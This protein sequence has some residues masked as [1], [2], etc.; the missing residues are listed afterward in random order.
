MSA[1]GRLAL[2]GALGALYGACAMSLV[3]L[4]LRRARLIDKM[5]PQ[6][7][8]EWAAR[9]MNMEPPGVP[10]GH[11]A[12]DQALH[13]I[14]SVGWGALAAPVLF[15]SG[16]RRSLGVGGLFGLGLW[17]LGPMLVFPMLKIARP[18]WRSSAVENLTN[19][20][21]HLVYGLGVQLVTEEMARQR[22]RGPS[23]DLTRHLTRVG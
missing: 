16:R 3:R 4:G 17:A 18:P 19:I 10:A 5:V 8:T 7:V 1:A 23:S 21:T 2:Y 9:A 15:R 14:Y 12:A 11:P 20:G 6:A 22:R 13:L